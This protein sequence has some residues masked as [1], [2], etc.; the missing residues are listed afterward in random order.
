MLDDMF[1][2]LFNLLFSSL[3]PFAIGKLKEIIG[4]YF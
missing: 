3:A 2:M 4:N 1:L